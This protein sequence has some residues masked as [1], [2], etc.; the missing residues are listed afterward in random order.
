MAF[1][2]LKTFSGALGMQTEVN[3]VI[4]QIN[5]EGNIVTN[6]K[7]GNGSL[8]SLYLLHGLSDNYSAWARQTAI[9]RYAQDK[10]IC[11]IMPDGAKSFY[12]D[13]KYGEKYYT[14]IAKELPQMMQEIFGL[15]DKRE[16][17]FIAGLSMGGYGALKIALRECDNFCAV[18][19]LSAAVDIHNKKR[20]DVLIPIFGE[21][22]EIPKEED[23]FE[24]AVMC[25]KNP[26]RPRIFMGE[27]TEDHT[28]E[29]NRSLRKLFESLDYDY[30]YRE[31]KGTHCRE[32]W[33]EYIKYVLDWLL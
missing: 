29:A 8:K 24:L 15:S 9:E 3:V 17:N 13:M 33:D 2:H 23:V 5:L 4:P 26:N 27:G 31:S 7:A 28:Y 32:V 30:T 16:D 11:V 1:C 12:T 6:R 18:A 10:G 21:K 25:E 19:A 14:Y 22:L 20:K